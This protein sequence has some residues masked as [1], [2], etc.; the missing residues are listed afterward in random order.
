MINWAAFT[1]DAFATLFTGILAVGA[2]LFVG[3]RQVKISDRQSRILEQ[4][5]DIDA[6]KY[7]SELFDR[8]LE[9]YD[10]TARFLAAILQK[11]AEPEQEIIRSFLLARDSARFLFVD[12]VTVDL[13][14]VWDDCCAFF[15][16]KRASDA[17]FAK[18]GSYGD[19]ASELEYKQLNVI[20]DRFQ[21]LSDLFGDELKLSDPVKP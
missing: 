3:L 8:R 5:A 17:N 7:R 1:W 21:N 9:V 4:Q 10:A 13:H 12:Q 15:A 14:K 16:A 19:S 18:T 11:A 2:A 6:L 20:N